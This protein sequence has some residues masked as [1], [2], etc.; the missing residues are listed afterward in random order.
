MNPE[1]AKARTELKFKVDKIIKTQTTTQSK[2]KNKES[3]KTHVAKF[4][5]EKE[6]EQRNQSLL[7]TIKEDNEL[8]LHPTTM[9]EQEDSVNEETN[10]VQDMSIEVTPE[11]KKK[12]ERPSQII[13]NFK[14]QKDVRQ[15]LARSLFNV[16]D[17]AKTQRRSEISVQKTAKGSRLNSNIQT[18]RQT[19]PQSKTS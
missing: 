16:N 14:K 7:P 18:L 3:A 10:T 5:R 17:S 12:E 8:L 2:P 4:L 15:S 13:Q 1:K 9:L 6:K 11:Q 19:S